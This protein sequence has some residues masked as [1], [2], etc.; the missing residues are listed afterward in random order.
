MTREEQVAIGLEA[1]K[2]KQAIFHARQVR[3]AHGLETK[4][5]RSDDPV[6]EVPVVEQS[7]K[8][9]PQGI[10]DRLLGRRKK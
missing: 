1:L 4:H 9:A 10:V 2:R 8:A 5:F 3:H 6:P 7:K